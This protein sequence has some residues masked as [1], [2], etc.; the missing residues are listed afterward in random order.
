MATLPTKTPLIPSAASDSTKKVR[1]EGDL[2]ITTQSMV[3]NENL[4]R[5][6]A[7]F[8][9]KGLTHPSR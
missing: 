4:K 6:K 7:L 9:A 1:Q 5:S 2:T 8:A 3:D